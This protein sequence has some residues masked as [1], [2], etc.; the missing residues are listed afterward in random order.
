MLDFYRRPATM[1]SGG[2]HA[3]MLDAVPR[4]LAGTTRVVQGLLLHEHWPPAY[5]V[6]LP[7]KRRSESHMRPA[8][9]RLDPRLSVE[10]RARTAA[11]PA[12]ARL[13]GLCRPFTLTL[14]R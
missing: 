14:P 2:E 4:D 7:D 3:R 10:D 6:T 5:G 12:G 9:R 1:T 13:A 8:S 11:P